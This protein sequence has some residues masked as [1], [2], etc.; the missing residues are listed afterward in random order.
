MDEE[1]VNQMWPEPINKQ[2]NDVDAK[3]NLIYDQ[4]ARKKIMGR[5]KLLIRM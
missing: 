2:V 4:V 1:T 3:S 5:N